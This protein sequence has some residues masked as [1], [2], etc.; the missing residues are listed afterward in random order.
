M[1]ELNMNTEVVNDVEVQE[2]V[3]EAQ[4]EP[5]EEPVVDEQPKV[6]TREQNRQQ[7]AMRRSR[8]N[9][10][11]QQLEAARANENRLLEIF[12]GYGLDCSAEEIAARVRA[13]LTSESKLMEAL[14]GYGYSGNAEEV[15]AQIHAAQQG[16]SYEEYQA[17]Q[18]Q[19]QARMR[20]MMQ[21]DP[22]FLAMKQKA[23]LY[24]QE[25]FNRVFK[26]DLAAIKKAFPDVKAKSVEDLGEKFVA[27]R[28][29]GIDAVTAFAAMQKGVEATKKPTP[30]V[31]GAVNQT[32]AE[33]EFYTSEEV[34][35]IER[36]HPEMLDDPKIF[37]RIM[38]SMTKW[39]K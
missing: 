39:G 19:Q 16:I 21:S 29:N 12:R 32:P 35:N 10:L 5:V 6:Q 13:A 11:Q 15:A 7:A 3:V 20:E 18:E 31:M 37:N 22:E 27:L 34:D 36:N 17:Q 26:D 4:T 2:P 24:E 8:E 9:D 1:E 14:K 30:P 33:K 25:A 28:A 23:D 38:K